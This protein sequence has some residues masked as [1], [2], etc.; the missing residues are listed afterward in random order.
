M[1]NEL[2]YCDLSSNNPLPD[3]DAMWADGYRWLMLKAT[4]ATGY[5]WDQMQGLARK[6]HSF[7]ADAHAGYY[8]WLYGTVDADAQF[9]AFWA[10][11][12]PVWKAGDRLM[13][14]FEDV[15]PSRWV[16]DAQ[17]CSVMARF[18]ALSMTKDPDAEV[19][20]GNWYLVNL[21]QTVAYL[22]AHNIGVVMS[23][24]SN[25]P[26]ANPYGLRYVAWQY[27]SSGRIA[28]INAPVDMN[29][30]ITPP[31]PE[32]DMPLDDADVTKI[33]N[34]LMP[35]FE[36]DLRRLAMWLAGHENAVFSSKSMLDSDGKTLI[37]P[38]A[39]LAPGAIS[40]LDARLQASAASALN[41]NELDL[42]R[43]AMWLAG[44]GNQVFNVNTMLDDDGKTVIGPGVVFAAGGIEQLDAQLKE[45]VAAPLDAVTIT[46]LA[47]QIAARLPAVTPE[48]VAAALNGVEFTG[49]TT[50]TRSA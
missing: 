10:Q 49:T 46:S 43:F 34:K 15:D 24:Y 44:H 11:V 23:D 4:E 36:A 26:P 8:H 14:D 2:V 39:V 48:Q 22:K 35:M 5:Y 42:K 6:W 9:A 33:V 50:I 27:T 17:H 47:T 19:Y 32:E 7:G 41:A 20:T 16:S 29:R 38:G 25:N 45:A 31:N 1:G 28:G 12:G 30:W 21:P 40:Q 18:Q 13:T 3:L 37:G